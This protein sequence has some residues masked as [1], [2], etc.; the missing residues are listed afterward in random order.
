MER[1]VKQW[2]DSVLYHHGGNNYSWVKDG[3]LFGKHITATGDREAME[4]CAKLSR[5]EWSRQLDNKVV[6]INTWKNKKANGR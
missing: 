2:A 5:E 1:I 6:D 4:L 3:A